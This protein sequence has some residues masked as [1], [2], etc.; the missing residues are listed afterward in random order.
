MTMNNGKFL[1]TLAVLSLILPVLILC[2]Q[3]SPVG[4]YDENSTR[5]DAP[6][7]NDTTVLEDVIMTG[8]LINFTVTYTDADGDVGDVRIKFDMTNVTRGISGGGSYHIMNFDPAVNSSL[9]VTYWYLSS[10]D[11]PGNYTYTFNVTDA[12]A[13]ES[14]VENG[15]GF[16]VILPVPDEGKLYGQVTWGLGNDSLP[17]PEADI[18]IHYYD[19]NTNATK[20]YNTT[21]NIT[22]HY[23]QTLPI[24][25]E[26]YFVKV[27]ATGFFDS[28][29]FKF[30]LL[31]IDNNVEKKFTLVA[32]VPEIPPDTT[33]ELGGLILSVNGD[34]VADATIVVVTYTDTVI[35]DNITGNVTNETQREY[36]NLTA[37]SNSTGYYMLEGI[38]PGNW[39][40][41]ASAEGYVDTPTVLSFSIE[42]REINFTMI[43]QIILYK[44][45]GRVLP[46]TTKVK[47]GY[48]ELTV[49]AS[50]GNFTMDGLSE[51]NYTLTLS[52]E[53]YST[54]TRTIAITNSDSSL[55]T[56]RLL[57]R[58]DIGP[59]TNLEGKPLSDV[60]VAFSLNGT[61]YN[62]KTD[63][64]GYAAFELTSAANLPAGIEIT[65]E[66]NGTTISWSH[67]EEIPHFG[68]DPSAA[69]GE[70]STG[71]IVAAVIVAAVLILIVLVSKLKKD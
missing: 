49:N 60:G 8:D 26:P 67:G 25:E 29:K 15:T 66:I 55:G 18:L 23:T 21:A 45:T 32:W 35:V 3:G 59:I 51:G 12:I 53:G 40:V 5:A 4:G 37:R 50:S 41:V 20:Y 58:I 52:L 43:T 36:K 1:T 71:M 48:S 70:L 61:V 65:A 22:G 9:G 31:T 54:Q 19:N 38:P 44:I 6:T 42:L 16:N 14:I 47:I 63:G 13:N 24:V 46:T 11:T 64:L 69:E 57:R 39:T 34:P 2:S 7:L 27:N 56:L 30:K 10:F 28:E 62:A 33:G 17:V 68:A